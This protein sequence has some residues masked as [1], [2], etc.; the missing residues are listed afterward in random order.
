[1]LHLYPSGW[2]LWNWTGCTGQRCPV[3][4]PRGTGT[5]EDLDSFAGAGQH[6][7]P[8]G[9]RKI[10][11]ISILTTRWHIAVYNFFAKNEIVLK[12]TGLLAW[13]HRLA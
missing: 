12:Q 4:P 1:M 11:A 5:S 7:L 13:T 6:H 3:P 8:E 9:R 10:P 2:L